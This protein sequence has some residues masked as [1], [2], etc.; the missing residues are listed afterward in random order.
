MKEK[1]AELTDV[2]LYMNNA[3]IYNEY[4]TIVENYLTKIHKV[5]KVYHM[6]KLITEEYKQLYI[7][8]TSHTCVVRSLCMVNILVRGK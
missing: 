4:F 8:Y 1:A 5:L 7:F 3:Q 2:E 6:S